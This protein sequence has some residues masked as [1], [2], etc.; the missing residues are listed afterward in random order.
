M[1]TTTRVERR[2]RT[3]LRTVLATS[4]LLLAAHG[5]TAQEQERDFDAEVTSLKQEFDQAVKDWTKA[6]RAAD[7]D[8]RPK[9]A[10]NQ[11]GP[12]FVPRFRALADDAAG[13]EAAGEA[14]VMVLRVAGGGDRESC[15]LAIEI[16]VNDYVDS[17]VVAELPLM[18]R[19]NAFLYGEE[20]SESGLR[21]LA[22][23]SAEPTVQAPALYHLAAYLVDLPEA[24]DDNRADATELLKKLIAEHGQLQEN[25]STYATLADG[26]LQSM[27]IAV[28]KPAPEIVGNDLDGVEFKLSDYRGKVV[29]LDFWGHW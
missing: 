8:E 17:K 27:N 11:P 22:T 16:L 23:E 15:Q 21:T 4:F 25:G 7:A 18:L 6:Y 9:L 26:L 5:A 12:E 20:L 24:T 19:R 28:G 10:A 2:P 14:W 1:Q 13:T 3:S 29:L